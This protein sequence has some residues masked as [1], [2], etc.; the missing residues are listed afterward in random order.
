MRILI[1]LAMAMTAV[2]ISAAVAGE[3]PAAPA[4]DEAAINKLVADLGAKDAATRDAAQKKLLA[5]SWTVDTRALLEKHAKDEDPEIRVRVKKVLDVID[6]W[7]APVDGLSLRLSLRGGNHPLHA[8]ETAMFEFHVRNLGAKAATLVCTSAP[9]PLPVV[10]DAE[11]REIPIVWDTGG[12]PPSPPP[13]VT[14]TVEPGAIVSIGKY[15]LKLDEQPDKKFLGWHVFLKPGEYR[16]SQ[17]CRFVTQSSPSSVKATWSGELTSGDLRVTVEKAAPPAAEKLSAGPPAADE[18]TIKKLAADLGAK[19]AATREVAQKRLIE[20]GLPAR[21]AL[22]SAAKSDDPEVRAR[23]LAALKEL[24]EVTVKDLGTVPE[25]QYFI[26]FSRNGEHVAYVIAHGQKQTLVCDGKE[27]PEWDQV[28]LPIPYQDEDTKLGDDG[29]LAYRAVK[30]KKEYLVQVGQ[31][32]KAAPAPAPGEPLVRSVDGKHTVQVVKTA[33]GKYAAVYDGKEGPH[34]MGIN[35]P[36]LF[37]GGTRLAYLATRARDDAV[38]MID[39]K[40]VGPY[41]CASY[42]VTSPDDK[43]LAFVAEKEKTR[44]VVCDGQEGPGYESISFIHFSADSSNLAYLATSFER[45]SSVIVWN[46]K[47]I[48]HSAQGRFLHFAPG[49]QKLLLTTAEGDVFLVDPKTGKAD[50]TIAAAG[51]DPTGLVFSPD[52]KH[53]AM[54]AGLGGQEVMKWRALVDGKVLGSPYDA[55]NV[56]FWDGPKGGGNILQLDAPGFSADGR[57]V[58]VRGFKGSFGVHAPDRRAFMVVDGQA[59]PEHNELWIPQGF[60]TNPER[61]R[62]VVRDGDRLRLV[63]TYWPEDMTWEKAV[64]N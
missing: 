36:I 29:S 64:K 18:T 47:E 62:Y 16:M 51:R 49:G 10:R 15:G 27:G 59:R 35:P 45:K 6:G 40:P 1:S 23:A 19:D 55:D 60:H 21:P 37:G 39:D 7:G 43:R 24:V 48:Y 50:R 42:F 44:H 25:K 2:V 30:D 31:E 54:A 13:L 28:Y 58:F 34:F 56:M 20:I 26:L 12:L 53:I 63:E 46:G 3:P 41:Q 22:A 38:V 5:I 32:D 14:L 33:D 11:G 61:L 57:H 4:I 52:G 8:G 17:V 9:I